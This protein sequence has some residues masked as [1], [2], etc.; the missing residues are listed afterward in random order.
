LSID[1]TVNVDP[2]AY[3]LLLSEAAD[4]PTALGR[5]WWLGEPFCYDYPNGNIDPS[6]DP[7]DCTGPNYFGW[8]SNLGPTAVT[9]TWIENPLHV[10]GCGIV[11]D[12]AYQIRAF[13]NGGLDYSPTT[14]TIGTARKPQ[15]GAQSWGDITGGPVA[16]MPGL[17][18]APEHVTNLADVQ[19]GIRTFE[20]RAED[21]GFPP[22]VWI[23]VETDKVVSLGD[24][25][26]LIS[27]FEGTTYAGIADLPNI[28]WHP[29]DCP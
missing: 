14:L 5:M 23:D 3:K 7:A 13:A 17:W 26:F 18:L 6:P 10:T 9:R 15:G 1:P 2:V 25:Q 29:A 27:A 16:G 12:V 20:N 4:Y 28:G 22:R 21:T 8:I 24:I 11:P 19:A